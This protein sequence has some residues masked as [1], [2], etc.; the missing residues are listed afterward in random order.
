MPSNITKGSSD[1]PS[2]RTL[3]RGLAILDCFDSNHYAWTL[4]DLCRSTGLA[5]ATAFRLLKTLENR[6][7]LTYDA[8]TGLYYLGPSMTKAAYTVV[9]HS[10]VVRVARPLL[11]TLAKTTTETVVLATWMADRTLTLDYVLTSRPFRPYVEAG[12]ML[13]GLRNAHTKVFLAFLPD[14]ER[15][16]VIARA[17]QE[18]DAPI[19]VERL[20]KRLQLVRMEGVAY[21]LEERARGISAAAAPVFDAVGRVR[22][23]IGVIAPAERFV[24]H[25]N[26]YLGPLKETALTL[27]REL[28]YRRDIIAGTL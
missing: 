16:Q 2:T 3:E 14:D 17:S 13:G 1:A 4:T 25:I 23:T 21:D 6:G 26:T 28:G 9:S 12:Q 15:A 27:S 5:K 10:E 11:E 7:Y 22:A 24:I 19:D 18:E 8:S 20:E